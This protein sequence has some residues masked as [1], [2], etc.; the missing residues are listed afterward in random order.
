M[1]SFSGL[2]QVFMSLNSSK[3]MLAWTRTWSQSLG[4]NYELIKHLFIKVWVFNR[5]S[6]GLMMLYIDGGLMRTVLSPSP[7]FF[8]KCLFMFE[9]DRK[10]MWAGEGQTDRQWIQ[11]R[12]CTNSRKLD[13][14]LERTNREI[15]TW[16]QVRC[17]TNGATQAPQGQLSLYSKWPNNVKNTLGHFQSGR[18]LKTGILGQI[19]F[20][21]SFQ[22]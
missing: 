14:G 3:I 6:M 19:C 10:S 16:A 12:F 4:Q 8:G 2:Y 5:I 21:D 17:S 18:Y 9:R 13:V 22:T 15:M 11:R 1:L 7:T 20:L